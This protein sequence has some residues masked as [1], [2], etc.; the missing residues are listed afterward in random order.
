M[1]QSSNYSPSQR[2]QAL[3]SQISNTAKLSKSVMQRNAV[4]RKYAS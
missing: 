2:S 4:N 3:I 1:I